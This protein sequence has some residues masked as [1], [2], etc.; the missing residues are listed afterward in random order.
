MDRND[1]NEPWVAGVVYETGRTRP[2][3]RRGGCCAA[4]LIVFIFLFGL[5]SLL[6]LLGVRLFNQVREA[7]IEN[8]DFALEVSEI[9]TEEVTE[10]QVTEPQP[11]NVDDVPQLEISTSPAGLDNFPGGECLP[12]QEIY[13]ANI[14]SVVSIATQTRTGSAS[15]TGVVLT[16][17]G[18]I[19]TNAHVVE[20]ALSATVLLTDGR[21]LEARLVGADTISDLAVLRVEAFDLTPAQFGDSAVLRVGD[22]VAAIGDPLGVSLR[23]TLTDGIVSAINRDVSV[24]GRTMTLIQTNAAINSGNSGGPLINCYGQVVGIITLKIGDNAASGGVEG[25]GFAIPSSTVRQIVNE[26]MDQGY[27]SGRPSLGLTGMALSSFYQSYFRLPSGYYIEEVMEGS[28]A[29]Q[30]GI[31]PGDILV[32]VDGQQVSSGEDI[33]AALYG[34]EVGDSVEIIISRNGR[35]YQVSLELIEATN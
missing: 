20:N 21:E 2:P 18:Y 14:P 15:G 5:L 3:K 9:P 25:I 8:D 16:A 13:E 7:V 28:P 30:V 4:V 23:G 6:S 22:S 31:Q 27:V 32:S 33:T 1:Y 10:P 19:V 24:G 34:F 29:Q 26:L 11:Q 12:L 35:Y 17:D